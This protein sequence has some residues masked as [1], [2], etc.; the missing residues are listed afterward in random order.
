MDFEEFHN[1]CRFCL[2]TSS[3]KQNIEFLT[4]NENVENLFYELTQVK[5]S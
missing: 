4:I 2:D 5:V 3:V 1:F